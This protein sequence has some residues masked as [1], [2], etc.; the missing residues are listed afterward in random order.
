MEYI[1]LH[2][3]SVDLFAD[4]E[5]GPR[6]RRS[7]FP[8]ERS[9]LP[10]RGDLPTRPIQFSVA[11]EETQARN[12]TKY[13]GFVTLEAEQKNQSQFVVPQLA[14]RGLWIGLYASIRLLVLKV[15]PRSSL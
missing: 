3:D 8:H 6:F 11:K 4:K 7:P 5:K 1:H 14:F 13:K 2:A 15:S 12:N 10:S 9:T